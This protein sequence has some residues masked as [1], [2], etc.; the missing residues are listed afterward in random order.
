MISLMAFR[1]S[2]RNGFGGCAS[3]L[4]YEILEEK[5]TALAGAA[6]R[7]EE[8]LAALKDNRFLPVEKQEVFLDAAADRA[9]TLMVQCELCGLSDWEAV[10]ADYEIPRAVLARIGARR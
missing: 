8:S 7:L 6:R 5:A 1:D 9:W 2:F 4:E 3:P 10:A